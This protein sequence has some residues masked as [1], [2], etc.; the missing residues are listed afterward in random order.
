MHLKKKI[1]KKLM[2]F[3]IISGAGVVRMMI[4]I[5]GTRFKKI[6]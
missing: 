2:D 3:P 6:K 5:E 1:L 4:F